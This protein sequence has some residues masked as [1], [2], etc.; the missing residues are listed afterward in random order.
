LKKGA[1][2]GAK[3]AKT[4][5]HMSKKSTPAHIPIIDFASL[6]AR[7]VEAPQWGH[8]ALTQDL[9]FLNRFEQR[10]ETEISTRELT[11]S[12]QPR[13]TE[14][15]RPMN[16]LDRVHDVI[17]RKHYSLRTEEGY[18]EAIKRFIF[19]HGKRHPDGQGGMGAKSPLDML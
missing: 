1:G 7:A 5:G 13:R 3:G 16:L 2:T 11:R 12:T 6:F 18:V 17:R 10:I 15:S 4:L 14:R 9:C 19:S 8:Q